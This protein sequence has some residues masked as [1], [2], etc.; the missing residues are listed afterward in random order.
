MLE[1]RMTFL[2]ALSSQIMDH[3]DVEQQPEAGPS[4]VIYPSAPVY[5]FDAAPREVSSLSAGDTESDVRGN[6][7]RSARW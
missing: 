2:F 3:S 1:F 5:A 7:F 6:F 4:T